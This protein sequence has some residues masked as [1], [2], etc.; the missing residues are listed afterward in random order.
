MPGAAANVT[1]D[2]A[3]ASRLAYE[4]LAGLGHTAIGHVAGPARRA[5]R[6][7]TRGGLP[8]GR[9]RAGHAEPPVARGA[10]TPSGGAEA[11]ER[12]LREHP[13]LTAVF[14]SSLAQAIGLLHVA[15]GLGRAVPADLSVIAYDELPVAEYLSPPV[16]TVAM[17]LSELGAAAV[18][19]AG[20]A[21]RRP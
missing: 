20:R 11:G 7:R 12:L 3:R 15:R 18:D 10:F 21:A 2:V 4:H 6:T 8:R 19:I 16:T 17:P 13:E 9:R 5:V 14:T 1:L